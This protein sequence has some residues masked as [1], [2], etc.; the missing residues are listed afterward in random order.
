MTICVEVE[1]VSYNQGSCKDPH[2]IFKI[3]RVGLLSFFRS[4]FYIILKVQLWREQV[5]LKNIMGNME[6]VCLPNK[7]GQLCNDCVF[8]LRGM[9][10]SERIIVKQITCILYWFH[11]IKYTSFPYHISIFRFLQ[12]AF[13]LSKRFEEYRYI[14]LEQMYC[15]ANTRNA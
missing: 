13:V 8:T 12:L 11:I 2:I 5:S 3:M 7:E 10:L 15:N 6:D 9:D 1:V 14:Q 4:I